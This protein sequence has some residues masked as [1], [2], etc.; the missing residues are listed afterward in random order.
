MAEKICHT[1]LLTSAKRCD[2]RNTKN[3]M[4]ATKKVILFLMLGYS[5][6]IPA[7]ALNTPSFCLKTIAKTVKIRELQRI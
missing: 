4:R 6:T 5:F 7:K 3:G 1:V 2:V